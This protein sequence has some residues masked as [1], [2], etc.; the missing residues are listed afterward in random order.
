MILSRLEADCVKVRYSKSALKFLHKLEKRSVQRIVSAIEGLTYDPPQGDIKPMQGVGDGRMRLRVGSWRVIYR[1]G[2]DGEI[3]VL[4][5]LEIG[6]R[7]D[8]Y[9]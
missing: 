2:I 7:G 5:V 9:K 6:N 8:I 4:L 3:M 1:Y